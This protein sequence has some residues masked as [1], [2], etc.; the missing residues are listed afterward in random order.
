MNIKL[1]SKSLAV[2]A[3]SLSIVL[4]GCGSGDSNKPVPNKVQVIGDNVDP[5]TYISL[6]E[7]MAG[8]DRK[9]YIADH[10][11]EMDKVMKDA[12]EDEKTRLDSVMQLP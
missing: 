6:L 10:K 8:P 1:A 7:S 3:L 2:A 12:T 4:V 9:K 5:G 11:A